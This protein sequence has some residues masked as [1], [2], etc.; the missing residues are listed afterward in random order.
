MGLTDDGLIKKYTLGEDMD[1]YK[2]AGGLWLDFNA[3]PDVGI[4]NVWG[5]GNVQYDSVEAALEAGECYTEKFMTEEEWKES[6][7]YN[8][9]GSAP[10]EKRSSIS[11]LSA[12]KT[13]TL[14]VGI[15]S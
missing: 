2:G 6:V 9:V 5:L 11:R 1:S 3:F 10:P 8:G 15:T 12:L 4:A 7:G 14:P 13:L